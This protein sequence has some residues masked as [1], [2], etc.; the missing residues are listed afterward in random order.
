MP[1]EHPIV[2]QEYESC[3]V[4]GGEPGY[5]GFCDH[6][7]DEGDDSVGLAHFY[8][9]IYPDTQEGV[10]CSDRI[11]A[12]CCPLGHTLCSKCDCRLD[13]NGKPVDI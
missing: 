3:P 5:L 2:E 1:D 9:C 11:A 4:C 12:K 7:E 6:G 10:E 13:E 8:I